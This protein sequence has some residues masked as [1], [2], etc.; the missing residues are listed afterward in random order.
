MSSIRLQPL[1]SRICEHSITDTHRGSRHKAS[2][3]SRNGQIPSHHEAKQEFKNLL[4]TIE[5]WITAK[6]SWINLRKSTGP[7]NRHVILIQ[8]DG[9]KVLLLKWVDLYTLKLGENITWMLGYTVGLETFFYISLDFLEAF[10]QII[11]NFQNY[12]PSLTYMD[13][14]HPIKNGRFDKQRGYRERGSRSNK[15]DFRLIPPNIITHDANKYIFE[16]VEGYNTFLRITEMIGENRKKTI[17]IPIEYVEQFK[18][19][20]VKMNDGHIEVRS[21]KEKVPES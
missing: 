8:K 18:D 20:I 1:K 13:D 16:I 19:V 6:N 9:I 11:K 4:S 7:E 3:Y 12:Y 2:A 10:L 5:S 17:H 21:D 15:R 14:F